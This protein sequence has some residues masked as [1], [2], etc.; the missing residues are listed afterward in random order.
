MSL[1]KEK[2]WCGHVVGFTVH[3]RMASGAAVRA[4]SFNIYR[5]QTLALSRTSTSTS[6]SPSAAA[7]QIRGAMVRVAS[8]RDGGVVR[9]GSAPPG[10]LPLRHASRRLTA[11]ASSPSRPRRLTAP[12]GAAR[13]AGL[14][15]AATLRH[16]AVV[17]AERCRIGIGCH[18]HCGPGGRVESRA[19]TAEQ[20]RCRF[21]IGARVCRAHC[22]EKD[23][24]SG[25]QLFLLKGFGCQ[26]SSPLFGRLGRCVSSLLSPS[27]F[28]QRF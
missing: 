10:R 16:L 7:V 21:S 11:C 23:V 12:R 14:L 25:G 18:G 3:H 19:T 27:L 4:F 28:F 2:I 22:T 24:G 20:S 17:P 26:N 1:F 5:L 15:L 6:P 13:R 8:W 9:V